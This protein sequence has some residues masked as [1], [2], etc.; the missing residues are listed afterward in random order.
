MKPKQKKQPLKSTALVTG[1]SGDVASY[2]QLRRRVHETL[3][4]GQS[5]IEEAKVR[6]YWDTGWWI[7]EHLLLNKARAGYGDRVFQ[8][9]SRDEGVSKSVLDRCRQFAEA[10][11][12][13][14]PAPI[15]APGQQLAVSPY[16]A[17]KNGRKAVLSWTHYRTLLP[18]P[19][20]KLR[21]RF[22]REAALRGWTVRDL[23]DRIRS[24]NVSGPHAEIG[25]KRTLLTP[26]KGEVC[27]YRV[28]E[29]RGVLALDQGFSRYW[30]LP[31]GEAKSFQAGDIVRKMPDGRLEKVK[32]GTAAL[33]YTFEAEMIRVVDADTV[34]MKIYLEGR[35]RPPWVKEKLRLRGL[36]CPEISTPEG[37]AAKEFVEGLMRPEPR[38]LITTTKPDKWDRYL[39][40]I[41]LL[42]DD[43]E[44][45]Y[46][47]NLL[48]SNGYACT[49][50]R[51]SLQDW[52]N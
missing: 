41:F 42:Q 18:V 31:A 45:L 40:D 27:T 32:G 43:G 21:H 23:Q 2:A 52:E 44:A 50:T 25:S 22:E 14:F 51:W 19:D 16:A 3:L 30:N 49:K 13:L 37:I 33:L 29:D 15:V 6:T 9:L 36:D 28:I 35:R 26:Q 10:F 1:K 20:G 38:V 5:F 34:W 39:S 17:S 11:P 12:K 24:S 47:N 48:L 4:R 8:D 46:L 7:R